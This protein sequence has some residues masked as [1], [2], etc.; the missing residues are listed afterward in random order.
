MATSEKIIEKILD[1][2][3]FE[4]ERH[5]APQKNFQNISD[6]SSIFLSTF[7]ATIRVTNRV[8]NRVTI[9]LTIIVFLC[10]HTWLYLTGD[11]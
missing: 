5:A 9:R 7:T 2:S 10:I 6:S 8:T 11:I 4:L 1:L 3:I